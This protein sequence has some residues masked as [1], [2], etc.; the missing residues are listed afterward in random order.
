MGKVS[1]R[2]QACI[3]LGNHSQAMQQIRCNDLCNWS[4][5]Q[6]CQVQYVPAVPALAHTDTPPSMHIGSRHPLYPLSSAAAAC[7]NPRVLL[8]WVQSW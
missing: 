2:W 8:L 4:C 6:Q 3:A 7:A 1:N 5:M